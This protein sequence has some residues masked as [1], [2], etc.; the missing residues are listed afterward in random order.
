MPSFTV[1]RSMRR[2]FTMMR[3]SMT[4]L[5]FSLSGRTRR[6]VR[7]SCTPPCLCQLVTLDGVVNFLA[8]HR[9]LRR[10]LDAQFYGV[11]IDAQDLHDDAAIDDDAFVQFEREDAERSEVFLYAAL[12]VPACYAGWRRKFPGDAPATPK[13][14]GC[15]V[16]R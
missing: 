1:S 8:M 4:M 10:R 12:F 11:A 9:Q 3:P 5:S 6:G 7:C 16:L 14:P 15:P 13:A 2:I